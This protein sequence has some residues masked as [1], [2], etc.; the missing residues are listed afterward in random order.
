MYIDPRKSEIGI[1]ARS[2]YL[3]LYKRFF[4]LNFPIPDHPYTINIEFRISNFMF[5]EVYNE[6]FQILCFLSFYIGFLSI[7]MFANFFG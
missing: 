2:T 1:N 7:F 3:C 5:I 6:L 4:K